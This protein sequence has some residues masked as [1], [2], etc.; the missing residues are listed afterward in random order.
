MTRVMKKSVF[1]IILSFLL[2]VSYSAGAMERS[3]SS[4]SYISR[5]GSGFIPS[6]DNNPMEWHTSWFL[7]GNA[8]VNTYWSDGAEGGLSTRMTPQFSIG[9]GVWFSPL[10]GMTL[11]AIGFESKAD[12]FLQGIYTVDR[13]RYILPDGRH[14][15][16]E[17]TKW[18]DLSANILFNITRLIYGYEGYGSTLNMNQII[19]SAGIG[20]THHYDLPYGSANDISVHFE[21]GY[22]RFF[23]PE[24]NL[25]LDVRLRGL[26]YDS[27]YD[28][29]TGNQPFDINASINV[30]VSY[31]F[32]TYKASAY[33]KKRPT[34][35][36]IADGG[37]SQS[38]EA[39]DSEMTSPVSK[40]YEAGEVSVLPFMMAFRRD[41]I[42]ISDTNRFNLARVAR[43]I[44][45]HSDMKFIIIGYPDQYD[46][47]TQRALWLAEHRA[48]NV[49]RVLVEDFY[50]DPSHLVIDNRAV[51]E[52]EQSDLSASRLGCV[53]IV[54]E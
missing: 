33:G 4:G 50:V 48:L 19:I 32:S 12:K 42:D 16:K 24:K 52:K 1:L 49:C 23:S 25:S 5:R 18:V 34:V 45:A 54:S 46:G 20:V 8:G 9:G 11:Q 13:P 7:F 37:A 10:F 36:Q 47:S 44:N 21:A 15:W 22:T 2:E 39:T 14:Y 35:R 26:F 29:V 51:P 31:Y 27:S 17:Q 40:G 6:K 38:Y 30:G 3:P 53:H 28:G 43:Y 41:R